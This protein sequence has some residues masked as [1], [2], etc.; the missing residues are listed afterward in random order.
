MQHL[1]TQTAQLLTHMRRGGTYSY[2]WAASQKKDSQGD[3]LWMGT[4]RG[5]VERRAG[6]TPDG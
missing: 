3:A 6:Q 5:I 4:I 2:F 1:D